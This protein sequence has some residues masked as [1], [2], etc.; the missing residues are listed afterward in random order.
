MDLSQDH[1]GIAWGHWLA[2]F[3]DKTAIEA[4]VKALL[5]PTNAINK[6]LQD[7]IDQA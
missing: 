3:N 7:L 5:Q 2:Q 1:Q 6:A 4:L